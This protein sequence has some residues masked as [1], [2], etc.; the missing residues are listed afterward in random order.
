MRAVLFDRD[1]TLVRDVPYN[2]RPEK[3]EVV[4]HAAESLRRLRDAG[5]R[6]GVI[7]NQ[8][9][10][11]RGLITCAQVEAVNKRIDELLGPFEVW[12]YCPHGPEQLC[13]CRK[14]LPGMVLEAARLMD[15]PPEDCVVIG[16]KQSDVDAA[17]AAGAQAILIQDALTL[18][19]ALEPLLAV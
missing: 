13:A 19:R 18:E 7:S 16:D 15:V 4:P 17:Q 5:M 2:G 8:S 10:V 3:V 12:L 9:G 6:L 14:P 11:A 1:G